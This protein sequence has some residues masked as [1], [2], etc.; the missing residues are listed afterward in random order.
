M[1]R[2]A[3]SRTTTA[4]AVTTGALLAANL[5]TLT[6]HD[7][8][9]REPMQRHAGSKLGQGAKVAPEPV[10][11]P[12]RLFEF[13]SLVRPL[14]PAATTTQPRPAV[15]AFPPTAPAVAVAETPTPV[16]AVASLPP[17]G[18]AA[19]PAATPSVPAPAPANQPVAPPLPPAV[20]GQVL[21]GG[22]AL[23]SVPA[24]LNLPAVQD[25]VTIDIPAALLPDSS[26][27]PLI[28]QPVAAVTSALA[29]L[30][31]IG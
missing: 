5:V 13:P 15:V 2:Q 23:P 3:R 20:S 29:P 26:T 14:G 31:G 21:P 9:E 10:A 6:V 18:P 7:S 8:P 19:G 25:L 16:S 30:L 1:T 27:S 17:A 24:I 11:T 4:L 12:S 22:S 28:T